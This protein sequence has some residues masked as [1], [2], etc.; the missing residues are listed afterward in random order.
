MRISRITHPQFDEPRYA[1]LDGSKAYVFGSGS[2]PGK[3]S[4]PEPDA[5]SLNEANLVAPVNPS[6][7]VCVG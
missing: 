6:K 2:F 5:L 4:E 1:V 3:E 7:I